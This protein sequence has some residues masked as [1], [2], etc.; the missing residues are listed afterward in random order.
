MSD[1]AV[2]EELN[3]NKNKLLLYDKIKLTMSRS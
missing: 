2:S 1:I 3:E